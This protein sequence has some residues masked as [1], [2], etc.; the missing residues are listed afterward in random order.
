MLW[1]GANSFCGLIHVFLQL[2]KGA[3]DKVCFELNAQASN[4]P[5][6]AAI[7]SISTNAE[8]AAGYQPEELV[9]LP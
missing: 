6:I 5:N 7:L 4:L 1:E 3:K 2:R 8:T 9:P